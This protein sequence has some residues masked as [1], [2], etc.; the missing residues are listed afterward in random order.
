MLHDK[1]YAERMELVKPSAIRELLALANQPDVISF[2][3][4]FPDPTLFPTEKLINVFTD[5]MRNN[6][7]VALQYTSSD[8]LLSLRQKL[9]ARMKKTGGV[10]C[11]P[12]NLFIVQGGQQGMDL[13]AKL[14]INKGDVIVTERPTFLGGLIAFNQYQPQYKCCSMDKDGMNMDELEEI[15]KTTKNVKFIYTIPDFQNPMGVCLSLERKKKMLELASKY[16]V[17]IL[18]DTPYREVRYEGEHIPTIKSMDTEDRVVFLGSFSKI[19]SPGMRLGWVVAPKDIAAKMVLLK[20]ATDTQCS[21]LNMCIVDRF[22]DMYNIDDHIEVLR[23]AYLRKRDVMLKTMKE[24]FPASCS[25]TVPQGGLFTWLTMA[26]N[27]DSEKVMKERI[28]P[29]ARAAYVPGA[30][31]FPLNVE[32][33]HARVNYSCVPDEKIIEGISKMGAI[34][35]QLG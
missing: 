25:W 19:L 10:D 5:V 31:F 33:N 9:C 35:K 4:G 8:G 12:D 11:T 2:G 7:G 18:E 27:L 20:M 23:T 1:L 13:M 21:T 6:G 30:G 14:F 17:M 32:H 26:P 24:T 29:E 16:D 15:L 34:L 22:M 3:G 28:L